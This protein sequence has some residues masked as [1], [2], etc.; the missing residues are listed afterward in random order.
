MKIVFGSFAIAIIGSLFAVSSSAD[1]QQLSKEEMRGVCGGAVCWNE[2][3]PPCE[4]AVV[5]NCYNC[6][7]LNLRDSC[8]PAAP[9]YDQVEETYE[10]VS[11]T[12]TQNG[13]SNHAITNSMFCREKVTCEWCDV[14][15][16]SLD[17]YC[18]TNRVPSNYHNEETTNGYDPC[19]NGG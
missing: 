16:I 13:W 3:A 10:S 15:P 12:T 14:N 6:N 7:L 4:P 11:S 8:A 17:K 2:I 19:Y 1:V 5:G 18:R 9:F